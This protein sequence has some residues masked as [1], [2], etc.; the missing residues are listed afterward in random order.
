[1]MTWALSLVA[2]IAMS[3][4]TLLT[5]HARCWIVAE[6]VARLC[7]A[8]EDDWAS[9]PTARKSESSAAANAAAAAAATNAAAATAAPAAASPNAAAAAA[10]AAAASPTA[11][12]TD[13]LPTIVP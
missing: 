10:S 9:F 4:R 12:A 13:A 8:D 5:S 3:D 6:L 2:I 7:E 1:M 11:T